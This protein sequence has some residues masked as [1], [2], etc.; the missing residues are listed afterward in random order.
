MKKK[1]PSL[2]PAAPAHPARGRSDHE[3]ILWLLEFLQR[4]IAA[5]RPGE[6][7]DLR[8]DVFAYLHEPTVG[9]GHG[10]RRR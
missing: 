9:D 7:L 3:R 8:N 10:L 2:G 1:Q 5:L 4:D 6:L